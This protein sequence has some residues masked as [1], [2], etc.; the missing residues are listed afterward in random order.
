MS[1][2]D[3]ERAYREFM[4]YLDSRGYRYP[5]KPLTIPRNPPIPNEYIY[6]K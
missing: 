3:Q 5:R 2:A 1:W 4:K 6:T